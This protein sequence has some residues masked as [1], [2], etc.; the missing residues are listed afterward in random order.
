MID[1]NYTFTPVRKFMY[2]S[3]ADKFINESFIPFCAGTLTSL[4]FFAA[5][6]YFAR[7][8]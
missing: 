7:R 3:A 6:I 4:S 5:L 2:V 8:Q 1:L